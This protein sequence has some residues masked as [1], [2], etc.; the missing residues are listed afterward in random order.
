M[1]PLM[2]Y[3]IFF[4]TEDAAI[5]HCREVNRGLSSKD[6]G[7]CAVVYGPGCHSDD[8]N[9]PDDCT[10]AAY[11]VVDLETAKELTD[12]GD[13]EPAPPYLVVTDDNRGQKWNG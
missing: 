8:E 13:D 7:C 3:C 1:E 12:W 9:H 2:D 4:E 11:A 6:S 5:A 10:C